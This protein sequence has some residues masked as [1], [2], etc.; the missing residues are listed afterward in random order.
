MGW[1]INRDSAGT[2]FRKTGA[3]EI[4]SVEGD[5]LP[6]T[7]SDLYVGQ[8]PKGIRVQVEFTPLHNFVPQYGEAFIGQDE[9][10]APP[11]TGKSIWSDPRD[12]NRTT[13]GLNSTI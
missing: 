5:I 6:T 10:Y 13:S 2:I 7:E 4:T 3:P 12:K 11:I 8:L 9:I 1:D